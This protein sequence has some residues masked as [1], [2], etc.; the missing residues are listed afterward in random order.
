MSAAVLRLA[1]RACLRTYPVA[2]T[3]LPTSS[4]QYGSRCDPLSPFACCYITVRH[5][6]DC[7]IM[8]LCF[9]DDYLRSRP[10]P[11]AMPPNV[12]PSTGKSIQ[13][14]LLRALFSFSSAHRGQHA[15][16]ITDNDFWEHRHMAEGRRRYDSSRGRT[17]RNRNRQGANGL[18]VSRGWS[19]RKDF[20]RLRRKGRSRWERE[21]DTYSGLDSI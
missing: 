4:F 7:Q 15:R 12:S 3:L 1:P 10:L 5:S 17:C 8:T 16:V 14:S 2:P 13:V 18:R 6:I 20:E 11:G 19:S 21:F 9:L